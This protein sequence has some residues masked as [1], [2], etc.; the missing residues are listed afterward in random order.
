MLT[1]SMTDDKMVYKKV[2]FTMPKETYKKLEELAKKNQRNKSNMLVYMIENYE[3]W[4]K[5]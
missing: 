1:Y 3:S 4:I 5:L 2:T